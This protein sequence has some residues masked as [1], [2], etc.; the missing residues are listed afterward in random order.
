MMWSLWLK[1]DE[2]LHVS[3]LI[4]SFKSVRF[5]WL[6][7]RIFDEN[8]SD[9]LDPSETKGTQNEKTLDFTYPILSEFH[10]ALRKLNSFRRVLIGMTA[11]RFVANIRFLISIWWNKLNRKL[12]FIFSVPPIFFSQSKKLTATIYTKYSSLKQ[13]DRSCTTFT[14]Y[15]LPNNFLF[16]LNLTKLLTK[17]IIYAYLLT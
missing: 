3:A 10:S 17:V 6:F 11:F 15:L 4:T 12:S 7:F 9:K 1:S 8:T 14:F 2:V 16:F 5:L 13:E